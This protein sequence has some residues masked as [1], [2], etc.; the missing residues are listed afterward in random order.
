MASR[1]DAAGALMGG[2]PSWGAVGALLAIALAAGGVAGYAV[3]GGGAAPAV[4]TIEATWSCT[5]Q[6]RCGALG[7]IAALR[8]TPPGSCTNSTIA[9]G[10]GSS[11]ASIRAVLPVGDYRVAAVLADSRL[12]DPA[13]HRTVTVARGK[14]TRLGV[15]TI[16]RTAVP[17]PM[18]CD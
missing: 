18:F 9:V 13:A 15:M 6:P 11:G 10:Q 5:A 4:G 14:V 17:Y 8:F 12:V 7:A 2:R 3:R 16:S 1:D